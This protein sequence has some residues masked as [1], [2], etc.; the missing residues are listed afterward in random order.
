[1]T[2]THGYRTGNKKQSKETAELI[3]LLDELS[4]GF[5]IEKMQEQGSTTMWH[6]FFINPQNTTWYSFGNPDLSVA[7]K[8]AISILNTP[9]NGNQHGIADIYV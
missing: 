6:I 5:K 7:L 2:Q 8:Y 4:W 9:L 3:T 1:M